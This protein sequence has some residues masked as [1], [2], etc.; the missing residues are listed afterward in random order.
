QK[1]EGLLSQSVFILQNQDKRAFA[2]CSYARFLSRELA[3]GTSAVPLADVPPSK[4]TPPE[5]V[6]EQDRALQEASPAPPLGAR[7]VILT[8]RFPLNE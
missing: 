8:V 3:L 2:L 6:L 7:S 4:Q 5:S 1:D